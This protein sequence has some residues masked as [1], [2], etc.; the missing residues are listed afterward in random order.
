[1][2]EAPLSLTLVYTP[3]T[4]DVLPIELRPPSLV[5]EF[6]FLPS[7]GDSLQLENIAFRIES[8]TFVPMAPGLPAQVQLALRY[9]GLRSH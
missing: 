6:P 4:K 5:W 9:D 3:D 1:M 7:T 8:R 2:S